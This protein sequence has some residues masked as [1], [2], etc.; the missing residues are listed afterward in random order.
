MQNQGSTIKTQQ[1]NSQCIEIESDEEKG[2]SM[3]METAN[4]NDNSQNSNPVSSQ[5]A[6]NTIPQSSGPQVSCADQQRKEVES[7]AIIILD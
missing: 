5:P 6:I 3:A 4:R 7:S 1:G 2:A